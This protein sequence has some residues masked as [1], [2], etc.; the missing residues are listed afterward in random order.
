MLKRSVVLLTAF[1]TVGATFAT[2]ASAEELVVVADGQSKA[3]VE[4]ETGSYI[5]VME[6]DPVVVTLGQD[7]LD[8]PAAEAISDDL[9][10][11]Q[12]D[13]LDDIGGDARDKVNTYTNSLNGFSAFL[14]Y[15]EAQTLAA[16]PKVS[17]VLPDEL[18]Q[19]TTNDSGA[20]LGLTRRGGAYASGITGEGVVVGIIDNGIWPEHPSFADD[21]SYPDLGITLDDTDRPNCEFGNAAHATDPSILPDVP[22]TCNQKL[23]G[24]RQMLDTYRFFIGATPFEYDSA[25]DDDG[26]GTHTASTAAG[27]A[28]VEASMYGEDLG[29]I[30]G[31]APRARV[32]AYKGLG[33]LG[34]FTSD[35]AAAIDQA[36]FDGV[37]VINYSI[38]GGASVPTGG[39]DIAFLFAANA[40]VFVATSAGN[41][42]PGSDTVGSPGNSPW[43][44]TVGASTQKRFYEGDVVYYTSGKGREARKGHDDHREGRGR[45]Y[46]VSGASLTPELGRSPFVDAEDFGN[47]LCLPGTFA[48]GSLDGMVV[49][50][51][52]GAIGR[53]AKG[54]NVAAAGG[55]GMVLYNFD[56]NDNLFTDTHAIPAVHI[57]FTDGLKLKAYIDAQA[58]AGKDAQVAIKDTG[59]RT[60]AKGAPSMTYFS[61]RGPNGPVPDIIKPDITAPG[62]QI[63]AGDSPGVNAFGDS[64]QA[65]SGTSMSSPH[66]AGL[67]ALLKQ[68]HP[69]WTPAMAKS[70]IMTTANTKVKAEDRKTQATPFEM[71]AGE[72]DPGR[73]DRKGSA[74][75]P[76]LVYDAGF[77]EY[78]GFLCG[79][80]YGLVSQDDCEFL[81]SIGI[82]S[83]ASDLNMASIGVAELAGSQTVIRSVTSVADKTVRYRARVK[84]PSGYDVTVSPSRFS[85][86]PG[87]TV[88]FEVTIVNTGA[89]AGEW[90]FGE[91]EL[92]GGGYEVASPI[93]VNGALFDTASDVSGTGVDG[94]LSF[95]VLF[96]YTGSYTAAAHGL[97]PSTVLSG[98]I[99]QDPDATYPSGDD[100][101]G[102]AGGVDLYSIPVVDSAFLR[103]ALT[104]PGDDDVDL[105]LENSS[106]TIIAASTNGGTDELIELVLPAN[107]TYTLAVH[108][109]GIVTPGGLPY[110]V[111]TWSVPL[112]PG[113]G[114]LSIDSAPASATNGTTGTVTASWSGL[115]PG[116]SY[117]G[118]VSHTGDAGLLGLTL[119]NVDT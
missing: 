116:T 58:A 62:H 90:R 81:D 9:E 109:W 24:A 65:I 79:A 22:F 7:A 72:I 117:L 41:S 94:S 25:R 3:V 21:G 57:N 31:I 60:K 28:G 91:L 110:A 11:E 12:D 93:A 20:Y 105:Y 37:D 32:I 17:L 115:A 95:D 52:R 119:V 106:G 40:G 96:G 92:Q 14:T 84:D 80:D 29:E 30:S 34:G 27:N 114:S 48:P 54:E 89:P 8:T 82:P 104:I 68:A 113:G 87:E 102:P 36:V 45:T 73:V 49:L 19:A 18:H 63:L 107:D 103:I 59:D 74:F 16:N 33:A 64:F 35:L 97:V 75:N 44:T 99:G 55:I 15:E 43:L 4:S 13:V 100:A 10:A 98:T 88:T 47:E 1:A 118:A 2:G 76:G 85:I 67:F 26:H 38:G 6:E 101:P 50:C 46:K 39:D 53:A 77:V 69:D 66:V 83:D 61:S 112:T 23:L 56:D 111:D 42:G 78:L 108:G 51:K 70:A 86:A 5:V 71:G